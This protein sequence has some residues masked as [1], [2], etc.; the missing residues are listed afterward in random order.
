[1]SV[2]RSNVFGSIHGI[3]LR[4]VIAVGL[5]FA[6]GSADAQEKK[7]SPKEAEVVKQV[8]EKKALEAK[9]AKYLSGTKWTGSFSMGKEKMSSE[10]Y[11]ILKAE[12]SEYGDL[13]NLMVRIKYGGKDRTLALPPIEIK[14]AGKTPVITVDQVFVPGFG[15]FDARVVI[16]RGKYAGTWQHEKVGGHLIGTIERMTEEEMA[17]S[18]KRAESPRRPKKATD[19]KESKK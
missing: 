18:Q 7:D 15:R 17:D 16:R 1:M 12:K 8:R 19:S 6:V 13:W 5:L 3:A 14:F 4:F 2:V 11:E 9:L 10:Y